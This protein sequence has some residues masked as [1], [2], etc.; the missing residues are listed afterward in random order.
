MPELI[1]K[2]GLTVRAE[3][4]NSD[5][6]A[7]LSLRPNPQTPQTPYFDVVIDSKVHGV[8]TVG[9]IQL[10]VDSYG[11]LTVRVHET[12]RLKALVITDAGQQYPAP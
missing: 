9:A 2:P 8:Q 7:E 10:Q 5:G 11:N 12:A 1:V 6:Y 3:K 4:L